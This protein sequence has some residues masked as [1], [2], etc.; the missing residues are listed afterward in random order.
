MIPIADVGAPENVLDCLSRIDELPR[1]PVQSA[2]FLSSRR[3]K[4]GS[5]SPAQ[6]I[7][8]Q[9]VRPHPDRSMKRSDFGGARECSP[10]V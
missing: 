5:K 2:D 7:G 9:S 6:E 1:L 3:S 10:Q 4:S 8:K